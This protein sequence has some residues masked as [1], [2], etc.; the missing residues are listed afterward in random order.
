MY[1]FREHP[2]RSKTRETTS[3]LNLA[4]YE[5]NDGHKLST[6]KTIDYEEQVSKCG[7]QGASTQPPQDQGIK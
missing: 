3:Q 5:K 7:Y 1:L 4:C 6:A 2:D